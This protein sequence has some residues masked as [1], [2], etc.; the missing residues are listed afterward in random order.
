VSNCKSLFHCT[1][2]LFRKFAAIFFNLINRFRGRC[3]RENII[4]T[5]IKK[6]GSIGDGNLGRTLCVSQPYKSSMLDITHLR[7]HIRMD[8]K[9]SLFTWV[10]WD[11]LGINM[12]RTYDTTGITAL[13]FRS[14]QQH[15]ILDALFCFFVKIGMGFGWLAPA[16]PWMLFIFFLSLSDDNPC[17]GGLLMSKVTS[18]LCVGCWP[19]RDLLESLR[20]SWVC[21][22]CAG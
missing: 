7:F 17:M 1:L 19:T 8:R 5:R 22:Y 2:L 12:A 20:G 3:A 10:F 16:L 18:F 13:E 15:H 21:E 6:S 11:G 14:L 9:E 4:T